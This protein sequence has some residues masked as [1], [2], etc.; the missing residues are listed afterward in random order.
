MHEIIEKKFIEW[1]KG[2]SPLQARINIYE[3]IRDIPYAVI[4]ELNAYYK[5]S[6]ILKVGRGSCT[7]KHLLLGHMYE[8]LGLFVLLS[9][10][11]YRWDNVK[12]DY[13]A[14]LKKLAAK[15]P[16]AHHLACRVEIGGQLV[17]V[18]ATLDPP[19]AKLGLPVN[20]TWDGKSN[21]I[22]PIIPEGEEE[23]FTLSE[24]KLIQKSDPD[25]NTLEFYTEL[26]ALLEAG[27]QL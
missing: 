22:L 2:K 20:E 1:T 25:N 6:E 10:F 4:P 23:L 21:T 19:L 9:V 13:P 16:Q 17:L 24:A 27:R 18:D 26:N 11:P 5:F 3:K 7:P 12:F 15:T 8:R 14:R